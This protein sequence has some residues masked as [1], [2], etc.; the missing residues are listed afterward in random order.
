MKSNSDSESLVSITFPI[1]GDHQFAQEALNSLLCQTYPNIQIM[2]LDNSLNGLRRIFDFTDERID[3]FRLPAHW[4]LAETL[5]FAIDNARGKYLARMDYDDISMPSRIMEQLIFMDENPNVVISGTNIRVIGNAI[6]RNVKPGQEV[7]RKFN[8]DEI[9]NSLLTNN[10]FF[11]PTVI[12]RLEEMKKAKLRYR[13][14]YDSAEDLDLWCRASR[15]VKL[16]N[17]DKALLQYRL[18]PNQY[19]RLDGSTSN[20]KANKVRVSHAIWLIR[21]RR[22]PLILG[23]KTCLRL[24]LKSWSLWWKKRET[25]FSKF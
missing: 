17:L 6:D 19:S 18:H 24:I 8:H 20:F 23:L 14:S 22:I 4:G 5:N 3:Y 7:K 15:V 25:N 10:A 1:H 13:K 11:H 21:M 2:F 12:F 9:T 16:A